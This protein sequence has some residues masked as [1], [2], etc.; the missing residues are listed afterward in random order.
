MGG[1]G[2]TPC[3]KPVL[4]LRQLCQRPVHLVPNRVARRVDRQ[5][6]VWDEYHWAR[7]PTRTIRLE[8]Q[9]SL[10]HRLQFARHRLH[11]DPVHFS[12]HA[13]LYGTDRSSVPHNRSALLAGTTKDSPPSLAI[14]TT[15]FDQ[16]TRE[17][18]RMVLP[19]GCYQNR[20]LAEVHYRCSATTSFLAMFGVVP[21]LRAMGESQR[22][23]PSIPSVPHFYTNIL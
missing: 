16:T 22:Y 2:P 23:A 18:G 13:Q 19:Q 4:R 3:F 15:I 9:R 5:H 1:I 11:T 7:H 17:L 10:L 8:V 20:T 14:Q 12:L 21:W 6:V